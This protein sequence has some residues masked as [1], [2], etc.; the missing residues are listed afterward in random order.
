VGTNNPVG[1]NR[2]VRISATND[3][4]MA[5]AGLIQIEASDSRRLTKMEARIEPARL[6]MPPTT[7]TTKALSVKSKPIAWLMPTSGPKRTPL[8]A[9][10]AAPIANT[11]VCTHGTGMPIASA[12]TRSCVVARIQIPCLPCFMKR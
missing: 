11:T 10:I 12:I 7:T 2:S 3:T 6:P 9:A 1:R 5:W 8:A 4:M